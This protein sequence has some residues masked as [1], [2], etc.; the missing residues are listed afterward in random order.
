MSA[1]NSLEEVDGT[2]I[3]DTEPSSKE[4]EEEEEEEEQDASAAYT[5]SELNRNSCLS[6]D[7]DIPL[8]TEEE[9]EVAAEAVYNSPYSVHDPTWGLRPSGCYYDP[10][11]GL[12][13]FNSAKAPADA[14]GKEGEVKQTS[15]AV[16]QALVICKKAPGRDRRADSKWGYCCEGKGV[17]RQA[18]GCTASRQACLDD[19]KCAPVPRGELGPI[20]PFAIAPAVSPV[21]IKNAADDGPKNEA[22]LLSEPVYDPGISVV[23]DGW[24]GDVQERNG[25]CSACSC[26][27]S[28]LTCSSTKCT[29]TRDLI[30]A[31]IKRAGAGITAK[32]SKALTDTVA[33]LTDDALK[34]FLRGKDQDQ[35]P[36]MT[37]L[38]EDSTVK[39]AL[40]TAGVDVALLSSSL[41]KLAEDPI[42]GD[43]ETAGDLDNTES[44]AATAVF[45]TAAASFAAFAMLF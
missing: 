15:A 13:H 4:D 11:S 45:S 17:C 10:A 12:T 18:A 27:G 43:I 5:S 33:G 23:A 40:E 39:S 2:F 44:G 41:E 9:C 37:A 8:A 30:A 16:A 42:P 6:P 19:P 28:K 34:T 20:F 29:D 32:E 26:K 7:T 24:E 3:Y 21:P 14:E 1:S 36:D 25:S 38:L 22:E 35:R 31:V